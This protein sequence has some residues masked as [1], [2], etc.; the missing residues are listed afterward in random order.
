[1]SPISVLYVDDEPGLL[2]IGKIFLERKG[3]FTV[4]TIT[5]ASAAFTLLDT[6]NYDVIISDY[7]MPGMDGIQFL[8]TIRTSGNT[9]PFILFTGRGREEVVI[10]ALNEGADFY[11]Q[12]GGEPVSQF[13]ELAHQIRQATQKRMAEASIRDYERREADIINF[14]PDATFAID[15][16]GHIIAWNRAIEEM[17]GIPPEAMLGKKEYEYAIPFYGQRQPILID[18]IFESDE[19]IAKKYAHIVHSKDTLLADTIFPLLKGTPVTL[20]A[21]AS[22]LYNRQGEIIGAIESIRDVTEYKRAEEALRE[23]EKQYRRIVETTEEGICQ[24]NEKFEIV[25]VNRRMADILG[26]TPE[27]MT[28][29]NIASFMAAEDMPGHTVRKEERRLVKSSQ[30]E[31]RFVTK[32]GK[33][34]WIQVSGTPI[35]DP[36]GTF[37][38]SFAMC[39][40]ITDRKATEE[41][42]RQN[43]EDLTKSHDLLRASEN[44]YRQIVETTNEGI[45]KLDMNF[46]TIYVNRRMADMLG[47]TPK[48]MIGQGYTS[49]MAA[50]DVPDQ[51]ARLE[52]RRKGK[53]SRYERRFITKDRK[54]RWIYVSAT[55]IQDPDGTFRGSFA[56]HS[57]I[58]DRKAAEEEIACRNKE[59]HAANEQLTATEEEL[60]QNYDELA[61]SQSLLIESEKQYRRIVETAK[62]GIWQ[63]DE[64]FATVYVNQQMADMFGYLP[65]EMMGRLLTSFVAEDD[66]SDQIIRLE[67]CR[68]GKNGRF[69]RRFVTKDGRI[70]WIQVSATPHLD[71]DGTF[72]GSFGMCSDITDRKAAEEE[73]AY[74]NQELRAAYEQLTATEEKLQQ[75]YDNLAK[76]QNLLEESEKQYRR[77]VETTEEGI[78]QL[79]EKL[80]IVYVNRRMAEMHCCTPEEMIG[81]NIALFMVA[82]EV[83]VYTCRIKERRL[84]KSS[85]YER[86]FIT[87]DGMVRWMQVSSTPLFDPDGTFRGSFAM[88]SD[89]TDHKTAEEEISRRNRELH[90]ANEQLTAT[91]EELRQNYDELAKSQGLLIESEKQYRQIVET[92]SEGICK[93]D[94]TFKTIYV[95]RRMADMLGYTPEK[96]TGKNYTSFVAAEDMP[97]AISRVKELRQGKSGRYASRFITKD[98]KVRWM[99]VSSTPL[100]DP[101]GTFRGSFA[102]YSDIT[103]QKAAEEEIS[104]RHKE[105]HAANEQLTATEEEL[106]QNYDELAKSQNLLRESEQRYR[107][108]IEDQTEFICRFLPDGTHVFVNEAYCRYFG[109]T[110]EKILGHRFRPVIP[111]EDGLKIKEMFAALTPENPV[112]IV[113]QRVI[114][115]D[116]SIRWQHWSDRAI[117]DHAGNPVEFQSV[118]RDITDVMTAGQA[119]LESEQRFRTILT[120]MQSGVLIIDAQTRMILDVNPKALEMIGEMKESVI[121]SICHCFICPDES[122]KCPVMDLGQTLDSSEQVL[123]T[124]HGEKIPILKSVVKTMLGE[125]EVLVES[126]VNITERKAAENA[127]RNSQRMLAEAMD[128]AN[129]VTWECDLSTGVLTFDTR[130]S[131]LYGTQAENNGITRMTA[132][133]YLRDIVYPEDLGVLVDE[134][135]K[136]R[137][138]TDPHYVSRRE[139]RIIRGDG[140]IRHIE[141][142]VGITKDTQGR[143]IKTHGVNQDITDLK[144]AEEAQCQA[145]KNLKLLSEITRHD[146]NN[147]LL[148]LRG[149]LDLLHTKVP[150]PAL[151]GYFNRLTTASDRITSMIQFTKE[152]ENIGVKAPVWQDCRTLADSAAKEA[153]LG[154]VMVKNDL[155]AGTEVFADPLII[156]VF[157]NLMDN[158]VRYGGKITTIRFSVE[159][160]D[161]H[162]VVVCEDDGEGVPVDEKEQIFERGFGKNTGMGLFLAR[163]ILSITGITITENGVPGKGARF[164]ITV[165]NGKYRVVGRKY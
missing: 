81:Q 49:F 83:P 132:E 95:N 11:L 64:K 35:M 12:K 71:P 97:V 34:R 42:L 33:I 68:Q 103:D 105:L 37:L 3:Q 138:T 125:R 139:Y 109:L 146:I 122:G 152:Y 150:D 65:E 51:T 163:E 85:R 73:I 59:L 148:T 89:I 29:G 21:K 156:K 4:D 31:R 104:R 98:R 76:S 116:G 151:E 27:E 86:R 79:D 50:E 87:K 38:G 40:D 149:F 92:T 18:L 19:I 48:E 39:S 131:T 30:Y 46:E 1:M 101:D 14:L 129:L 136:T 161:G 25:Y 2:E 128:L 108:V 82:E 110:R 75:N 102:M 117:Y 93:L 84:G 155:P 111:A 160:R 41:K 5:S 144:R 32:D 45:C 114:F 147:Q 20:M 127:L 119:L 158:A 6:K 141:M 10:Q 154:Q 145:N 28:G 54:I 9:I 157:Y 133:V 72:R 8:K 7:Q 77:I 78:S 26:Y 70:R 17:T 60:R 121:G 57:D 142:C 15:R 88:Y 13:T 52:E 100:F 43:Y 23:S 90:A 107:N 67:E 118:G 143:T 134:D 124:A 36:D 53:S 16:S 113:R 69:E 99:Q 58:T 55:P 130:F 24:M 159:E 112:G 123:L 74:R 22:P 80:E 162:H 153:P 44:Q 66:L 63:I 106:R 62:E 126:F 56:M 164:E 135:E 115:P 91:E 165:L 96:M 61:K 137:T 94:E 120:L 47:Y 140:E